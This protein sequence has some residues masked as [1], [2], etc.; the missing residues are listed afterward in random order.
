LEDKLKAF[1]DSKEMA[2]E[3]NAGTFGQLDEYLTKI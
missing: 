2:Q 1:K 3:R